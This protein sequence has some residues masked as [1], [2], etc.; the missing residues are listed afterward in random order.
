MP[1]WLKEFTQGWPMIKA[2][3]PTFI[4]ILFL[5]GG[6]FWAIFT[7]AYGSIIANQASEIKLLERQ[8]LEATAAPK[9]VGFVERASLSLHLYP[10]TRQPD[11]LDTAENVW[12]WYYLA[13]VL[14]SV[15]ADGKESR[16]IMSS[17]LFV[18]FEQPV[19]VGT[20]SVKADKPLT[21]YEVKEFNNRFA[22]VVFAGPIPECNV[23]LRVT[24]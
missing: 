1:D 6:A 8:K 5:M 14:A 7:W 21:A 20:L 10:D 24:K 2:N 13:D 18:T 11:R 15:D 4:F 9:A 17:K 3:L 19:N 22:I 16:R 12:R 23:E